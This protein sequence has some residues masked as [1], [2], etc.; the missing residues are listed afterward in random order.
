MHVA[1]TAAAAGLAAR[2]G[3]RSP[4]RPRRRPSTSISSCIRASARTSRAA[5]ARGDAQQPAAAGDVL[6]RPR[7][8]ARRDQAAARMHPPAHAAGHGRPRQDPPVAADRRRRDGE[9]SRRRL[10]RRP[11]ADQRSAARAQR[12][13]A[14]RSACAKSPAS[15]SMQTLCEHVKERALLIVLDNCEHLIAACASIADALLRGA[16][17]TRI[18]ATSRE[19]LHIRGEQ[20][21]QVLP[22]AAPDRNAGV[23]GAAAVGRGAT[24]RRARAAAEAELPAH[25]ARRPGRRR[26]LRAA[27]RHSARAR[28]RRGAHAVALG[29]RDQRAAERPLQAADR[30]QPRRA[31]APADAACARELVVRPAAGARADA[32][33]PAERVR[34]RLRPRRG[35]GG[36]RRRAAESR[37]RDRPAGLA[38]RE[39][40]GHGRAGRRRS[41]ATGCSRRSASSR[42]ST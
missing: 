21:Y 15:R 25:R 11:G 1:H 18:L 5:L 32:A 42:A 23:D 27:R 29:R 2:S 28:A 38:G 13:R 31:G 16:P 40:A 41:R 33:R 37:R 8:R 7:A 17:E 39:I 30:R 6:H 35:R 26:A 9:I 3:R 36:L 22:L 4:A 24:L 19:A 12:G 20:S 14:S 10:V 34:R